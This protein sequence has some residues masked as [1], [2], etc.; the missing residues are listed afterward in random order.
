VG[1]I[2][3]FGKR[4]GGERQEMMRDEEGESVGRA[5]LDDGQ[6]TWARRLGSSSRTFRRLDRLPF[7]NR[8]IMQSQYSR[9]NRVSSVHSHKVV[10]PIL[11]C[12][13]EKYRTVAV[14][15]FVRYLPLSV[16]VVVS[17]EE[18]EKKS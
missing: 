9:E 3:V 17:I 11:I 4:G 7:L 18:G 5:S 16:S 12:F 13:S 1:E 10:L 15:K 6:V 8:N 2:E 14:C